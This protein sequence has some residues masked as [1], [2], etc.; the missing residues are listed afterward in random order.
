MLKFPL[1]LA[2]SVATFALATGWVQ[3]HPGHALRD[4]SSAHLLTNPDHLAVLVLGGAAAWFG[5]R[6]IERRLPRRLLQIC[7]VAAVAT[8][9]VLWGIRA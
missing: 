6:W 3:A 5:A 9:A 1:R 4:A 7:G 8:A 2:L